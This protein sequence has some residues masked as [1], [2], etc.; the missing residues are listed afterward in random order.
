MGC[1]S[2][3]TNPGEEGCRAPEQRGHKLFRCVWVGVSELLNY[4]NQ[5]NQGSFNL[6]FYVSIVIPSESR[7]LFPCFFFFFLMWAISK[8]FIKYVTTLLPFS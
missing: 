1:V 3:S 5:N 7:S 2:R 8:V 6:V 4:V